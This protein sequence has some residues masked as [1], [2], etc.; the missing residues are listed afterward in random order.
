MYG[1]DIPLTQYFDVFRFILDPNTDFDTRAD[2]T[3]QRNRQRRQL[4]GMNIPLVGMGMGRGLGGMV[5]G[6]SDRVRID[7][8]GLDDDD[9]GQ[10]EED[11]MRL[12]KYY[13][14]VVMKALTDI[15]R[16]TGLSGQW[17]ATLSVIIRIAKILGRVSYTSRYVM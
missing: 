5:I 11:L 16:D 4:V 17:S 12:D 14:S 6:L 7:L 15:L 2:R 13:L 10:E 3:E 9:E 1:C 8:H